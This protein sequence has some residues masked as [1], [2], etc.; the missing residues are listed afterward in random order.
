MRTPSAARASLRAILYF[1]GGGLAYVVLEEL[2]RSR[3]QASG[4]PYLAPAAYI[5]IEIA[6]LMV[7]GAALAW[8]AA[9]G[10]ELAIRKGIGLAGDLPSRFALLGA[11]LLALAGPIEGVWLLIRRTVVAGSPSWPSVALAMALIVACEW[12]ALWQVRR[13]RHEVAPTVEDPWHDG[14]FGGG[15]SDGDEGEGADAEKAE[16]D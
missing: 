9:A 13:A 2:L 12:A 11:W 4:E 10:A 15:R 14:F 6:G 1:T 3:L 16:T 8:M 5:P 7:A